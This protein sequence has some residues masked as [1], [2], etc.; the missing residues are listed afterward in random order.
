MTAPLPRVMPLLLPLLLLLCA[1]TDALALHGARSDAE[2]L[3]AAQAHQG[4]RQ[5]LL[6]DTTRPFALINGQRTSLR[7]ALQGGPPERLQLGLW[8]GE[9]LLVV[10]LQKNHDLLPKR[11][12]VFYYLPNGTGVALPDPPLTHCF[13]HGSVVGVAGSRVAL[14][15]CSG[16]RG[17]VS[18]NS[19]LTLELTPQ[20]QEVKNQETG[21]G[22]EEDDELHL[23][24]SSQP[25]EGDR[26]TD[27]GVTHRDTPTNKTHP[28]RRRRGVLAETKYIELVLVVDHQEF[29]NYEKNNETMIY[30][31]LDVANQVDWFY[32]PLNVRVA[33][34]GLEIW[35]DR[36]KIVIEKNPTETLH[37]FL[38]W[39]TRELLPRLR[40]DNAQLIMGGSFDGTTVGMASQ[41][42]MCSRDRSGGVNVDHLVSVLGV[43]STVAHE[44]G[45]NL[46]MNHD[47]AE[48]RCQCH[49]E[50]R[51]GGCIMEP[52]TGL[53]P[54]QSFSSCS[55]EDLSSSLL[56]G[57]GMCLYNV[58]EPRSL[59]GGARCGNLYLEPGEDCDCGLLQECSD[60]C[61]NASTC[62]LVPGAECSSDG[63][64]CDDCKL[65]S[66]GSLCRPPL[67]ECDLPEFCSGV[68]P[69]C[70]PNVFLQNGE[71]CLHG[72]SYCYG[73]VCASLDQQCQTLWGPS[74]SRAPVV[75]FSTVNKQG[76]KFGNCGQF[77]NGSYRPC[78]P[79]DV[80]CGR[81]QC[82][83]G[84]E[85][86]LLGSAE[87][88]TTTVRSDRDQDQD[89]VCRGT[90]LHLGHDVSDPAS[91]APGTRCGPG[92]VCLEQRCQ[93]D[94]VFRVDECR[95]K[96]HGHG[97]CNS[98]GN[99]HCDEGWAPPDCRLSGTGGSIDSGP[100]RTTKDSSPVRVALLVLFLLVLPVLVLVL[101]W[102]RVRRLLRLN[103][104]PLTKPRQR[105]APVEQVRSLRFYQESPLAPPPR[106]VSAPP[107]TT[108]STVTAQVKACPAPPRKPLPPDPALKVAPQEVPLKPMV[109]KKPLPLATPSH[110]YSPH[111]H[112]NSITPELGLRR[113]PLPPIRGSLG[114]AEMCEHMV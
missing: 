84:Q 78:P 89:L 2:S 21:S 103:P 63:V 46:G 100:T 35:S 26:R 88:L 93:D 39:R 8:F 73:G 38:Q 10:D 29:L 32:R 30:R 114:R 13:Y 44:L 106:D 86:P 6:L 20:E 69:H 92:K 111:R 4:L 59:L 75:C 34:T 71:P 113:S 43:A 52:S 42:S 90:V 74:S 48:R 79:E 23:L 16:L 55:V 47:S 82:R 108:V 22:A 65:R 76:N 109:P 53:M 17:V 68:S 96:C 95:R 98:N 110:L 80:L 31:M 40:H 24:F 14:S 72:A 18:L 62:R 83:G 9:R 57:G 58:P 85:R 105:R 102:P 15:T 112:G 64:C 81:V 25:A 107:S 94:S 50:P 28:H 99:C 66:S 3:R 104:Q 1:C 67:G 87:I 91:V 101:V 56:R 77:N 12:T 45:H 27:C 36:D 54:G 11:P 70:P 60:P 19:T 49:H 61:C 51:T 7:T 5:R 33:L 97:V 41:S 37:N